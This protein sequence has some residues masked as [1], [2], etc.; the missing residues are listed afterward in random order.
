NLHSNSNTGALNSL[1]EISLKHKITINQ[2][3]KHQD[4]SLVQ[5]ESISPTS[6]PKESEELNKE[7]E[8]IMKNQSTNANYYGQ[9]TFKKASRKP[10]IKNN[11]DK[12]R[13]LLPQEVTSLPILFSKLLKP[14]ESL[15]K[16]NDKIQKLHLFPSNVV[17]ID[18]RH[19]MENKDIIKQNLNK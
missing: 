2:D 16:D 15:K 18:P 6:K 12:D 1:K 7:L 17:N 10:N 4:H 19:I 11:G 5:D 13:L 8:Y 14:E 3:L 9:A